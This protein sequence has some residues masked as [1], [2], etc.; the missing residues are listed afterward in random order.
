VAVTFTEI[1]A[2][3]YEEARYASSPASAIVT[4]VKRYVNEG[5]R[6]VLSEP[7]LARL[8]DSDAPYTFA[9][10]A[11]Q[12]RYVLPESIA[13]I[14][15]VSERTNDYALGVMALERYRAIEPDPASVTGTP[16]HLVPI[17]RVAVAVQP[18]DAS[19][20]FVKSSSASDTGTAYLEGIITGGYVRTASVSMTGTTAVSLASAIT[21]FI[22]ITDFY[23]SANA[24]GTVTLLEDSG[25]G[26][27]LAQITI[28]Q[29][30]PRYYG[31]YLWPTPAAAVTYYV[32]Y[33]REVTDLVN[34]TDEPPLPLDAHPMLVAYAVM[35]ESEFQRE[36][37][38]AAIAKGRY[39]KALSR[40]KYQT[41]TV[42]DEI[43][44]L[45]R[46]AL[47]GHSRLGGWFPADTWRR[48]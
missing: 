31:F 4:R 5:M 47:V 43:P 7:G 15:A 34:D 8:V 28:G 38:T 20:I 41:Q 21:S 44:V 16:T 19:E 27:E 39:D 13:R 23:I 11:S 32:D 26:T 25:S 6:A 37:E 2:A 48:G 12:A 40:L 36:L 46:G 9:S 10:V 42:G 22:E 24:V 35:R 17:G 45:G 29:K 30:R 14:R 33:R 18:A 1:L 3:V